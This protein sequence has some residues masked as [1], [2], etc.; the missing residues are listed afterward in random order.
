[1]VTQ[2][3][4]DDGMRAALNCAAFDGRSGVRAPHGHGIVR[5]AHYFL[6]AELL[7]PQGIR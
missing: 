3:I 4:F 7:E 1:M 5:G 6:Q 2:G